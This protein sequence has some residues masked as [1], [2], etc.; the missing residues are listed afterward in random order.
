[1]KYFS[2]LFFA[3]ILLFSC[4][5]PENKKHNPAE[6]TGNPHAEGFDLE[7][8][9]QKAIDIADK[10][11]TA[12]GGR[13]SWDSARFFVWN[14]FDRRD[15]WWDKQTGNVRIE[16]PADSTILLVNI[17]TMEGKA[18]VKG[19]EITQPDSLSK[20]LNK[21][22]SIWI[23]DAYWLFM[24]FKLKDTG[25]TLKYLRED[26]TLTGTPSDVVQLTF[27]NVGD[28]P[29]NKYEVWVDQSDSLVK[30]WA[31]YREAS[32]DSASAIWPWDNYAQYGNLKL[33][34]DR[35]DNKGPKRIQT[36]ADI[37]TAFFKELLMR[38]DELQIT[39]D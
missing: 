23:N 2:L 7:N 27:Q 11:M 25:V 4:S 39:N 26:T 13:A 21:A 3:L 35:S 34:G 28:T 37:P 20:L 10:V 12:M 17:H 6:I 8:S 33:S 24:P 29:Q 16:S 22:K 32:Q 14:F 18:M 38:N 19:E 36:P 1:M 30:Q 9:D 5:G 15:L 31:F